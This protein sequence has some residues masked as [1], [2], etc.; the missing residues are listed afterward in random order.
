M[1]PVWSGEPL[2]DMADL[3]ELLGRAS[4]R[5]ETVA[6]SYANSIS[7]QRTF[8]VP[9]IVHPPGGAPPRVRMWRL[10]DV[11]AWMDTNRP[12]W[13]EAARPE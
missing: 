5:G 12:G 6:R 8:P 4:R 1:A 7:H 2:A 9:L 3:R 10:A 11:E 13:R